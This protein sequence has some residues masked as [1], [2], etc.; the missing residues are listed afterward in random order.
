MDG[1]IIICLREHEFH[2][3]DELVG[4]LIG[5]KDR[6]ICPQANGNA[7]AWPSVDTKLLSLLFHKDLRMVGVSNKVMDQ[8]EFYFPTE[9]MDHVFQEIVCKRALHHDFV[10]PIE[11]GTSFEQANLDN[12]DPVLLKVL[13]KDAHGSLL[14]N[15]S[16]LVYLYSDHHLTS[17]KVGSPPRF[18]LKGL[19]RK[20][21]LEA[22]TDS[23]MMSRTDL[24]FLSYF[25]L[26][27]SSYISES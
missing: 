21:S 26:I 17:F 25:C 1:L 27:P 6:C 4:Q 15:D 7:I 14:R 20:K 13:K 24:F 19:S 8:E 5:Y 10:H 12:K 9:V 16:Y 11:D 18:H 3:V 23:I 22:N 2:L